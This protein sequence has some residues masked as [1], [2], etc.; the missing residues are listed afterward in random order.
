MSY[1][2]GKKEGGHV[3]N[4]LNL[5]GQESRKGIYD[6]YQCK[7]CGIKGRSYRLGVIEIPKSY[8][9]KKVDN[10]LNG[11]MGKIGTVIRITHCAAFG[12]IF[13]NLTS[14]S[15]HVVIEPPVGHKED[16][17]GVWVMG[18]GQP[19][20]VLAGEYEVI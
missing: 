6:T 17:R 9:K 14:G 18:V 19:V 1:V 12:P 5:V 10:C 20:K 11:A 2:I 7:E 8:S 3:W 15:E 16:S 13:K 4:K